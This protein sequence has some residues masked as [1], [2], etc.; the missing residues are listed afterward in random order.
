[1]EEKSLKIYTSLFY[2][3][4]DSLKKLVQEESDLHLTFSDSERN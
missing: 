1:M 4:L 3:N 2:L